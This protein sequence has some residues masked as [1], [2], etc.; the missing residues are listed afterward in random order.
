[1]SLNI[2]DTIT[3]RAIEVARAKYYNFFVIKFIIEG[4]MSKVKKVSLTVGAALAAGIALI[5][6]ALTSISHGIGT[7]YRLGVI[8]V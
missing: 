7:R 5:G 4:Y 1:M 2:F 8:T 6:Y 3:I